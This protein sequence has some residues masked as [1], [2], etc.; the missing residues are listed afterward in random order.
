LR[1]GG[2]TGFNP[3]REKFNQLLADPHS[4]SEAQDWMRHIENLSAQIKTE[5][6]NEFAEA[7][8]TVA[9]DA[10]WMKAQL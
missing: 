10:A 2:I 8:Q 6:P 3:V 1:T 7:A 4:R 9:N 5:F